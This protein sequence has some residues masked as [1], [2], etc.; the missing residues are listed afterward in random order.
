MSIDNARQEFE[1]QFGQRIK[2]DEPL[3]QYNS[4]LQ[5]S[6]ALFLMVNSLEELRITVAIARA[7][8]VPWISLD[9]MSSNGDSQFKGIVIKNNARHF[10]ILARK[11]KIQSGKLIT[12]YA[13]IEA[14][15]G[16]TMTQLVRYAIDQEL[17]GIED[18]LGLSRTVGSLCILEPEYVESLDNQGIIQSLKVLAEN[19]EVRDIALSELTDHL[20][21][22]SVI[23]KLVNE[24]KKILWLKAKNA[25]RK[26]GIE[27]YLNE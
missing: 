23:F 4:L 13:L 9:L 10:D 21:V 27:E 1:K 7:H 20:L 11:G 18:A 26:R 25:A 2:V 3:Q 19:G 14:E 12:D 22:L 24:D 16:V 6:A 8:R 15:S 17:G 5:S